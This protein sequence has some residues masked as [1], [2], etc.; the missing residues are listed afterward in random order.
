MTTQQRSVGPFDKIEISTSAD[1][2]VLLG[3]K[4]SVDIKARENLL[5]Y[6]R[7]D[8]AGEKL[9]IHNDGAVMFNEDDINITIHVPDIRLLE[10]N[11]AS[12]AEIKGD[13]RS[14][15]F[16]LIVNGAGDVKIDEVHV[17]DLKIRL[18]GA[19]DVDITGGAANN[20]EYRIAGA[21]EIRAGKLEA[22]NALARIRGAGEIQ[23]HASESLAA[24][25]AGAGDID[26]TGH[27]SISQHITGSGSLNNRN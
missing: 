21:G 11:G 12:D 15:D 2:T 16:E 23:L 13:L 5:K 17:G 20:A 24:R 4:P 3:D 27:P 22:K 10:I 9:H 1:V 8:I 6:I 18:A 7:T 25:I 19:C 14:G 26:Y